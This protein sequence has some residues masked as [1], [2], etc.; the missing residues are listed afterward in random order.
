MWAEIRNRP[1]KTFAL[2]GDIYRKQ[3]GYI[4]LAIL[5]FVGIMLVR[6]NI[7]TMEKTSLAK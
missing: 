3:S 4:I 1:I 7:K 6:I 5:I 2:G